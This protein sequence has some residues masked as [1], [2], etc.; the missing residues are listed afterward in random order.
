MLDGAPTDQA[1][2]MET[3][4][5]EVG[6]GFHSDPLASQ[7]ELPFA[8]QIKGPHHLRLDGV[9]LALHKSKKGMPHTT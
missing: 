7:A 4:H 3:D 5:E 6:N 8:T 2:A 1:H 9:Q